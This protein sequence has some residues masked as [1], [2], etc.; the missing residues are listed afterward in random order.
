MLDTPFNAR[1][2]HFRQLRSIRRHQFK[3]L[4]SLGPVAR[5]GI[6]AIIIARDEILRLPDCLRHH[7]ALGVDRFVV[8]DNG[9]TDGT[10][11]Y[12]CDQPDVD[13]IYTENSYLVAN[14]AMGWRHHIVSRYG[15]SRWY[16]LV[17]A[18][19]LLV[20]DGMKEHDLHK[21]TDM[22]KRRR[23]MLL[24]ATLIDMYQQ[25]PFRE[26]GF[27][28]GDSMLSACQYF[29]AES[30]ILA[31]RFNKNLKLQGGPRVRFLSTPNW[32]FDNALSKYPLVFW[33]KGVNARSIH[34]FGIPL[35]RR[36]PSG[37][38]LHFKFLDDFNRRVEK[39]LKEQQHWN[40]SEQYQQ[41]KE[42]KLGPSKLFYE[43]SRKY[44]G[45]ESLL[46]MRLMTP[47]FYE[48]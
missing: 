36:P 3:D 19:E 26:P 15:F 37:A 28:S 8:V 42:A 39:A 30:Y 24:H 10:T 48:H 23:I 16:L 6:I 21:L 32:T 4:R 25:E 5:G 40:R 44:V 34:N 1:I 2:R 22:L 33:H 38:L 27:Q 45:P 14:R 12:I 18:D 17:D 13:V 46:S 11:D 20:Y 9:S 35:S 7:R 29:D 43:G 41:Y 47:I 31:E